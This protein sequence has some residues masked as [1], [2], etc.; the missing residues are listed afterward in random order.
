VHPPDGQDPSTELDKVCASVDWISNDRAAKAEWLS[1]QVAHVASPSF[2]F[3]FFFVSPLDMA[4]KT[5]FHIYMYIY[6]C[7]F[8]CGENVCRY[9]L[10]PPRPQPPRVGIRG[11]RLDMRHLSHGGASL[12]NCHD[13]ILLREWR[14]R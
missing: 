2:F 11:P 13:G 3:F 8:Y 12:E 14:P 7:I 6:V 9:T 4:V 1:Q 5:Y 10:E